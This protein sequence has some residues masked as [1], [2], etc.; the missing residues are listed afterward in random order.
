MNFI[1]AKS[2]HF[3]TLKKIH[4]EADKVAIVETTRGYREKLLELIK[5]AQKRIYLTALYLQDDAAGQ[6]VLHAIYQAKQANPTLDVKIFVDFGRAQ[7]GLMGHP[8]SI[9]N[10]RLYRECAAKYEHPIDILGVPV[11]SREVLGVLHL[12]GYIFDNV[13][14]YSGASINDIY[15]QQATRYRYDRYHVIE[16]KTI[17]NSMVK[18]LQDCVVKSPAVKDLTAEKIETKKQLKPAI[19]KFKKA[20]KFGDYRFKPSEKAQ[21]ES[22]VAITPLL[23]FGGRN[24]PLNKTI[25]ELIKSTENKITIYTPYFNLPNKVNKAVKRLL[26]NGKTV[27]IV[28]GDKKANDFYIP[29]DKPCGWVGVV[30]YVYETNLRRFIKNNQRYVEQGLLNVRLWL[31]EDNSFHL[32]GISVDLTN[33]LITGHNINPRAW[34]LDLENGLLIQD[35]KQLLKQKF[36]S[37][38][39]MILE[40]TQRISHFSQIETL[41]DYPD[42]VQKRLRLVRTTR[43]ASISNRLL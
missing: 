1:S 35:Q 32:K 41:K 30:P 7:R 2:S 42:E 3:E 17:T 14:F 22:Q 12:K 19:K 37:E 26:K 11:K 38:N 13:L 5:T 31:H 34:S 28:V 18:F 16:D 24:N 4:V 15:L 23:G 25:I 43:A 10:V 8:E 40:H 21:T 6:E 36:E 29:P 33:H 27:D 9:G 20:L 39:A